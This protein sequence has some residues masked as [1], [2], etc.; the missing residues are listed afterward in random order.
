MNEF[1]PGLNEGQVITAEDLRRIF[2]CSSQGGMRRSHRTNSL[3]LIA[4]TSGA[5]YFDRWEGDVFLYTG[6]GLVGDQSLDR[7]QNRTLAESDTNGVRIFLFE[8]PGPNEYVFAGRVTLARGPRSEA[9]RDADGNDR[10]VWVF[11][12]SVIRDEETARSDLDAIVR[13]LAPDQV[14]RVIQFARALRGFEA[15]QG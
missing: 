6:M 5:T 14:D 1:D 12:L 4:R 15:D 8:N 13:D 7:A 2:K 9:Q 10:R 3:V 11:P